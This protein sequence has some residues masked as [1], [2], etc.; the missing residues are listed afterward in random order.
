MSRRRPAATADRCHARFYNARHPCRELFRAER[1]NRPSV[2]QHRHPGIG[3]QRHRQGCGRHHLLD[4]RQQLIRPERTIRADH[5]CAERLQRN[6]CCCRIGSGYRPPRR[7]ERH[8]TNDR[9]P[10]VLLHRQE[11]S[12]HFL[13]VDHRL[14][15]EI[16]HAG[17]RQGCYLFGIDIENSIEGELAQWPD[18]FASWSE[19][20][21]HSRLIAASLP[22][23]FDRCGIQGKYFFFQTIMRKFDAI[24]AKGAGSQHLRA[25]LH[26]SA[27]HR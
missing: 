18:Q 25:S 6:C 17:F 7:F 16:V 1:E 22:G 15:D 9:H 23:D 11:R 19:I 3:T 24:G 26:V 27:V 13:N 2:L 12:P 14:N 10:S 20:A 4:N 8:L 21:A 5:I